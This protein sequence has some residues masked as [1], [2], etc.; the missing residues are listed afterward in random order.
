MIKD[1]NLTS[2]FKSPESCEVIEIAQPI[3]QPRP[4]IINPF[5]A[6]EVP[7]VMPVPQNPG[8]M[9]MAVPA[10]PMMP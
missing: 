5:M 4:D 1:A 2:A 3:A 6:A 10:M 8:M 7:M 9:Q